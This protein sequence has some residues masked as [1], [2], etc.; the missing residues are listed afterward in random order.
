MPLSLPPEPA[1]LAQ[2]QQYTKDACAEYGWDKN[3]H[4]AIF[5]L[6]TEEVGELAQAV[7]HYTALHSPAHKQNDKQA[8]ANELADVFNYLTDIANYFDIDLENAIR[9]KWTENAQRSWK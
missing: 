9:H 8:I 7:R 3:S 1:T 6:L 4:L 5:L 2:W